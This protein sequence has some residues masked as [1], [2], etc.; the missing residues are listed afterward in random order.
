MILPHTVLCTV[1]GPCEDG[2]C[3]LGMEATEA[4]M[5]AKPCEC[6]NPQ[7][8]RDEGRLDP[9][10]KNPGHPC[11]KR[12]W[13]TWKFPEAVAPGTC[14]ACGRFVRGGEAS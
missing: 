7:P 4:T 13:P 3:F 6:K 8:V 9:K 10:H 2:A 1:P 14:L 5:E 11:C 12:H